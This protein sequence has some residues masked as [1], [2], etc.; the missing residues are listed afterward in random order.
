MEILQQSVVF[1]LF[2][3]LGLLLQRKIGDRAEMKGV[4]L[5]ILNVALPAT[6]FVALVSVQLDARYFMLPVGALLFN[7]ILLG[8]THLFGPLFGMEKGTAGY[9]T[10]LLLVPSLAPGLSC[11][12]F[13]A[14]FM[15]E[16]AL[17]LGALADVG[18]KFFVLI[19]CY[20]LALHWYQK[21][22]NSVTKESGKL[23]SLLLSML[24]EPING[25]M[26][27]ALVLVFSGY[28][29]SSL[30][31]FVEQSALRASA[32]MTPLV[33]LFIGLSVRLKWQELKQ[34]FTLLVWR[35][36]IAFILS[37]ILLLV[38]PGMSP[39]L[40]L[41]IVVFPQS[42]VSFWPFAHMTALDKEDRVFN[43]SLAL[44]VLACSLPYSTLTIL[45][46]FSTKSLVLAHPWLPLILGAGLVCL[47]VFPKL[48]RLWASKPTEE[49]ALH[50]E[51]VHP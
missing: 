28:G 5:I 41:L 32:M 43:T 29:L 20:L 51:V 34:V 21:T 3:L 8:L 31:G 38:V 7:L 10:M 12:P 25:V 14:E 33:L 18:N 1:I 24:R 2:I 6:I 9:H 13:L 45:G 27:V 48:Y 42:A 40:Q 46:V 16:D 50:P 30:P 36:G 19:F 23:K 47:S 17:A 39:V 15:G 37:G 26:I 22:R 35:S 49:V 44:S 4:K 11:F